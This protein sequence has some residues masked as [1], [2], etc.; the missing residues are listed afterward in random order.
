VGE[1]DSIAAYDDALTELGAATD[2][3]ACGRAI[4]LLLGK[5]IALQR[6]DRAAEA[7]VVYDS[8]ARRYRSAFEPEGGGDALWR[9]ALGLHY[10]VQSLCKLERWGEAGEVQL[11]LA[12]VLDD[13]ELALDPEPAPE[14][15]S[16][17]A[18]A[19]TIAE[20]LGDD[21][22]WRLFESEADIPASELGDRALELYL[23]TEPWLARP[24]DGE[25]A[26][27]AFAASFML[28][29]LADGYAMLAAT[30]AAAERRKLPLPRR[31]EDERARVIR[32]FGIDDWAAELGH[33]LSLPEPEA[34]PPPPPVPGS[35][36]DAHGF[37]S[38]LT[39]ALCDY[40][41]LSLMCDS[42]RGRKALRNRNFTVY[43]AWQIG[44]ARGWVRS[45]GPRGEGA[46][47]GTAWLFVA[48]AYF[49]A[50]GGRVSAS[51][52][53]LPSRRMLR[54]LVREDDGYAWLADQ[55]V[56]L[57]PWLVDDE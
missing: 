54:E 16:E 48:Q 34:E 18:L 36:A 14:P 3:E 21:A 2:P 24:P 9:V 11:Q 4:E 45:F 13:V 37:A 26:G 28:R 42:A 8:A 41:L 56:E 7:I 29:D 15:C 35:L 33:P 20:V 22:C 10:K 38:G 40:E 32:M 17:A 44:R 23:V 57:P 47:L 12:E 39:E 6:V 51:S 19:A 5:G 27:P 25:S 53:L 49:V 31:A 43:A 52:E 46:A 30:P 55:A 50:A 1:P